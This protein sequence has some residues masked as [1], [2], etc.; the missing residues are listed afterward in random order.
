MVICF[1]IYSS[2]KQ[3]LVTYSRFNIILD[4]H[5]VL[6]YRICPELDAVVNRLL[7]DDKKY[8]FRISV[9]VISKCFL[10]S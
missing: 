2:I 3:L 8:T 5:Y 4:L 9:I 1:K 7:F 10:S 6:F